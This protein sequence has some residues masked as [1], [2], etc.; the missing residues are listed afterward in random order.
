MKILS[1]DVFE[2]HLPVRRVHTWAG[3]YSAIGQGYI[4]VRLNVEGGVHGVGEAQVLKDWGGAFGAMYGEAP[5]TTRVL[6]K[7]YLEPII[8]GEDVRR[9]A[10]V[11]AKMDQYVKGYPYAKAAIDVAM[12]DAVGKIMGVPVYQLL[13]GLVKQRIPLA[14]SIGLMPIEAAVEEAKQVVDEGINVLKLKV[15]RD[16]D[17][18]I[19]LVEAV[20]TALPEAKIRVD[21]NQGYRT[22]KEALRACEIMKG[23]GIWWMEQPCEG[24]EAM[25]RVAQ[26]TDVPIMADEGCWNAH[27]ALRIIRADAAEM[28]SCYYTKAGGLAKARTL[29]AV[30]ETGGLQ[31]DVNGSAEMG[32]GNAANLH[33]AAASEI[34]CLPGT[35]PVTSTAEIERTR[36]AGH[37]YMDDIIREPFAYDDGHLVVPDGPGLGIELDMK[38]IEKYAVA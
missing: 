16:F 28:V 18:D 11:H 15:G 8:V 20:R 24:L 32:V 10:A 4:V 27:D 22:W 17:R 7:E 31:A 33:L 12:H 21:A 35:I 37:K 6:L 2:I 36:I 9:I 23:F 19:R 38:K 3:N 34:V 30:C 29:L 25:A 5:K 14:H 1:L 13:G 26:A